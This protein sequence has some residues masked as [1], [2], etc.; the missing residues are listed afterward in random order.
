MVSAEE[1]R[2]H[3]SEYMLCFSFFDLN[4][5]PSIMPQEGSVYI[6]SSSEPHDEEGELDMRRLNA[7]IQ[8]FGMTPVGVPQWEEH[9][10]ACPLGVKEECGHW[11]VPEV[12]RGLHAS[13]HATGPELLNMVRDI[14]PRTFI[15]IHSERP[16]LY[17]EHL[18]GTG[19]EVFLP[20]EGEELDL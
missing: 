13:G 2:G 11:V 18:R 7:W 4:E 19:I 6:Y 8:R 14:Q 5:L 12:E 1:V 9:T 20:T 15:P 10:P 17:K 3:Q 16:E